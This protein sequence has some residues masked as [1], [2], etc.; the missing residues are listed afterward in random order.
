MLGEAE[1]SENACANC[2]ASHLCLLQFLMNL[3]KKVKRQRN[4]ALLSISVDQKV[5]NFF[6]NA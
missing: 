2:N 3:K 4:E 6:P 1:Q 5:R